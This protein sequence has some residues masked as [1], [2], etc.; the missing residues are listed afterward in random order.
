[1]KRV[2][3]HSTMINIVFVESRVTKDPSNGQLNDQMHKMYMYIY[4][5]QFVQH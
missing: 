3:K 5:N 2:W 1:M 4:D